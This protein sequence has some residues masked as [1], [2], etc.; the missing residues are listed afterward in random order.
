MSAPLTHQ[1]FLNLREF[2]HQRCGIFLG[3]DKAYLVEHRLAKLVEENQ[4]KS[5]G[6]LYNKARQSQQHSNLCLSVIDAITTNETFWFREPRAFAAIKERI[7]PQLQQEVARGQR[8]TIRL[9]SAACS[10]GQEPYSMAM[11]AYEFFRAHGGDPVCRRNVR[12][13]A[14]DISRTALAQ[15]MDGVYDAVSV[16]RGLNADHLERYFRQ[17]GGRWTIKDPVKDLVEF[18]PHNLRAP[19]AGLGPFEI[20]AL[21]NVIIYFSEEVKREIFAR[22]ASVMVPGGYLFLGTGETLGHYT[23]AFELLEFQG[24]NYYR[25]LPRAGAGR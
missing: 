22:L 11:T 17:E 2:I 10:T 23:Q 4:C 25:L 6:E 7:L 16:A 3:D 24:L 5:F 21:R 1:E 9:W 13:L 12:I 15:A 14:T 19:M 18:K 8:E 20:V